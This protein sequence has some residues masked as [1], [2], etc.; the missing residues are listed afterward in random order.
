[1]KCNNCGATMSCGCQKRT[2]PNG[3]QGCSKCINAIMKA[4][5]INKAKKTNL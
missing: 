3:K 2:S 1:M 4:E 5:Q